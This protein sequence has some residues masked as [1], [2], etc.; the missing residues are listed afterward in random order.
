MRRVYRN[1][2][3]LLVFLSAMP[4][5]GQ[6]R[7][8][9]EEELELLQA[10]PMEAI[11]MHASGNVFMPGEYLYYSLY[12]FNTQSYRLSKLSEVAYVQLVNENNSVVFTKKIDIEDGRGYGDYFFPADLPSGNYKLLTYTHWMKNAGISQF[13]KIDLTFI[14]P[15]RT[16]QQ[17]FLSPGDAREPKAIETSEADGANTDTGGRDLGLELDKP[18][19]AI[20]EAVGLEVKNFRGERG[21]GT[22]SVSVRKTDDLPGPKPL[23]AEKYGSNYKSL[24]RRIPQRVNDILAVPEQRGELISGRISN[25]SGEGLPGRTIAVSLPGSDFQVK[26]VRTDEEG[27]FYTYLTR[28]YN[29]RTGMAQIL[30]PV[31]E[32]AGVAFDW[33]TPYELTETITGFYH[34]E[35]KRDMESEIRKRS[36]HNQIENNYFEVKPDT[37]IFNKTS[38]PFEGEVPQ[39]YELADYTRFKTLR[40]TIIEFIEYVWIK[41]DDDGDDTFYVREPSS[42]QGTYYTTDPPLVVVDGILVPNHK[43]LLSYDARKIKTIKVLR[44]KFQ[45]GGAKLSGTCSH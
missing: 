9:S 34:F 2:A 25:P 31:P 3:V 26:K 13:F 16:D 24:Q 10:T 20:G 22:F 5:M 35:L 37:L 1:I 43:T 17:V 44:S 6:V 27:K 42:R 29:E 38:D 14:N 15:Y 30:E 45:L 33:Y 28:A 18:E 21:H 23:T 19:Y 11:Y 40:E 4:V 36:I 12:C 41:K 39:V 7:I 32:D 8:S